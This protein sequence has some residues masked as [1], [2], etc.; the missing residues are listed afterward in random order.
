MGAT[1]DEGAANAAAAP[2]DAA[3][4][5]DA[6]NA[7]DAAAAQPKFF[8]SKDFMKLELR[9]REKCSGVFKA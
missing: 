4:A 7:A 9:P 6:A 8:I 3:D 5:A 2:A 1:T